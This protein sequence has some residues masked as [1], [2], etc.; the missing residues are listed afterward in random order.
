MQESQRIED[1]MRR[2]PKCL[3]QRCERRLGGTR[4]FRMAAHPIDHHQ[5]YRLLRGRYRYAILVF[6]AMTDQAHIRGLDLQ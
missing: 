4:P 6:L 2:L 3:E 5:E 1:R